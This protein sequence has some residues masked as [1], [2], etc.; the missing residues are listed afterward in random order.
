MSRRR[1]SIAHENEA[2]GTLDPAADA[3]IEAIAA[4]HPAN[5]VSMIGDR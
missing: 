2:A 3:A 4:S 1:F 5:L